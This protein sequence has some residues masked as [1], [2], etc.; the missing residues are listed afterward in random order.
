MVVSFLLSVGFGCFV[1][2]RGYVVAATLG[3][4]PAM[5][6]IEPHFSAGTA[7]VFHA[8]HDAISDVEGRGERS[9]P[10]CLGS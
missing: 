9:A 2:E 4:G 6:V 5:V 8:R 1:K 7:V 3:T 10:P